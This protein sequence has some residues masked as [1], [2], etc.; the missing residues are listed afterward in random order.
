MGMNEEEIYL[1][2]EK[3]KEDMLRSDVK[4]WIKRYDIKY[5]QNKENYDKVKELENQLQAYKDKEDKIREKVKAEYELSE[6]AFIT[7]NDGCSIRHK[8]EY[9]NGYKDMCEYILQILNEGDK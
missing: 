9:I 8:A 4:Y 6:D 2:V 5:Q 7:H 3:H 1:Q